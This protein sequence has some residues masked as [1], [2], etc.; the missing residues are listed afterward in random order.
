MVDDISNPDSLVYFLK[1]SSP[2]WAIQN[3]FFRALRCLLID[4]KPD[5]SIKDLRIAQD[6]HFLAKIILDELNQDSSTINQNVQ[7]IQ[8]LLSSYSKHKKIEDGNRLILCLFYI[9]I[10][11]LLGKGTHASRL[12]NQNVHKFLKSV[13]SAPDTVRCYYDVLALESLNQQENQA[14]PIVKKACDIEAACSLLYSRIKLA[15]KSLRDKQTLIDYY[16]K[17]KEIDKVFLNHQ[18]EGSKGELLQ[19]GVILKAAKG[20]GIYLPAIEKEQYLSSFAKDIILEK[21]LNLLKET[22]DTPV[23]PITVQNWMVILALILVECVILTFPSIIPEISLG[24]FNITTS[25]IASVPASLIVLINGI[26]FALYL[27]FNHRSIIKK[28]GDKKWL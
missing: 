12:S 9:Y 15:N 11:Q 22:S 25:P 16:L 23:G 18:S 26:L 21:Y 8:A 27:Y 28:I 1:Q 3:P 17:Q 14:T 10:L 13:V 4:S 24:P 7:S 19:I 2:T 6:Y 5:Y 20:S